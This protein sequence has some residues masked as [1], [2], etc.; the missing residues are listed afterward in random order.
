MPKNYPIEVRVFAVQ[1][2]K[3]GHTWERVA[4]MVRQ[5]FGLDSVP[6]R[7]QMSKWMAK[8]SV[9]DVV[10]DRVGRELPKD[11]TQMFTG[12]RDTMAK[13][14]AEMMTG[15]D[16]RILIMKWMFSQMKAEFGAQLLT[17][18]WAE[19][20]EEEA[21]LE[22]DGNATSDKIGTSK[23]IVREEGERSQQ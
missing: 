17:A 5:H 19:F 2:K 12:Q 4:E 7:R 3:E 6:S 23:G 13:I 8:T 9:S 1:R 11:V 10:F 14:F 18:A 15:K 16:S 21:R 20:T 22:K